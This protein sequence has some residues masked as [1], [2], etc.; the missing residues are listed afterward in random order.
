MNN[1]GYYTTKEG[2]SRGMKP[3]FS[4]YFGRDEDDVA[5]VEDM[6]PD[7][8]PALHHAVYNHW[9]G[10]EI[11]AL[12]EKLPW[13]EQTIAAMVQV[14]VIT[15]AGRNTMVAP[16]ARRHFRRSSEEKAR[17]AGFHHQL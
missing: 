15:I 16:I 10:K 9:Q 17:Y 1:L 12:L 7:S 13:R 11:R 5:I 4:D 14:T 8:K 6:I 2:N 3:C